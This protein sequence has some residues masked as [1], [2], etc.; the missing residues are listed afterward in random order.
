M[1][2]IHGGVILLKVQALAW[3][4]LKVTLPYGCFSHYFSFIID[5]AK[6]TC[7]F[8]KLYDL[9]SNR[10]KYNMLDNWFKQCTLE[11]SVMPTEL[12]SSTI[13]FPTK[14]LC[15]WNEN[16]HIFYRYLLKAFSCQWSR[17]DVF[18]NF[19]QISHLFLL[20]I[21]LLDLNR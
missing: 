16:L 11:A 18:V 21:L 15:S 9:F 6:P 13:L 8:F 19:E 20:E 1:K 3:S 2:N 12:I 17:F 4:L 7:L 10:A 5:N 14:K